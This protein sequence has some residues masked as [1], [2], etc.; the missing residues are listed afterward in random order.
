ML[1]AYVIGI[2]GGL[3]WAVAGCIRALAKGEEFQLM[4]FLKTLVIGVLYGYF[5]GPKA[6]DDLIKIVGATAVT[7]KVIALLKDL[8]KKLLGGEEESSNQ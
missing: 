8:L 4:K 2:A 3:L 7:D 5:V 1:P 6:I